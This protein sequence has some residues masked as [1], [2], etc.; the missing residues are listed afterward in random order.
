M[1]AHA[2]APPGEVVIT[3]DPMARAKKAAQNAGWP[4]LAVLYIVG[5][6]CWLSPALRFG[7]VPGF[8]GVSVQSGQLVAG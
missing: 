5:V 3:P 7:V 6:L 1:P 4:A 2:E 8:C